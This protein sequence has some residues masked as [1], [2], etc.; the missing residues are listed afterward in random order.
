MKNISFD[1][2]YLL[3]LAIPAIILIVVPFF[4]ARNKDNKLI[5]WTLSVFTHA[6]IIG[7]VALA[8]AGMSTVSILTETTVYVV[9][10]ISHSSAQNLDK[11]DEY[12][13]E[14]K[15]NLPEKTKL[16]VVCF[17]KG[18]AI[19]ASPGRKIKSVSTIDID[20]SSTDIAKALNF[21]ANLFDGTTL[22]RI[23]LITDG[24]D[25]VN[26]SSSTIASTVQRLTEDGIKI[27]AIFLD[28]SVKEGDTEIQLLEAEYSSSTYLNHTN[29]AKFLIQSSTSAPIMLE[30]F[31]RPLG[32][33]E[34][35]FE[36]INQT[37]ISAEAGLST[38]TM[39]LPSDTASTYEYKVQISTE[40]DLSSYNNT[41]TFTQTV[42]GKEK[43]LLIS[44][45]RFDYQLISSIYGERAEID[46][47]VVSA[48]N[49]RVPIVL[50]ELVKY[51]EIVLSDLD[52]REIRNVNAFLDSLDMVVSQ[53]G[54]SLITFG[55]LRTQTNADDPIF[56]KLEEL[57]P[58]NYGNTS[59]DG[60]LYTIVLDVSHSMFM[61][62]KFDI[63]KESAIQLIS[64]LDETDYVCLVTFSGDIKVQTPRKVAD[65]KKELIDYIN[66][67]KTGHGTDIGLG[68]EEAL[69]VIQNL[70]LSENQIMLISDG[71]SF[72]SKVDAVE[73]ATQLFE[74]GTTVSAI[75]TYIPYEGTAGRQTLS[76]IVNTGEGGNFYPI[77]TPSQVSEVVF[78]TVA[79]DI[80]EVIIEREG[81]VNIARFNDEIVNGFAKLPNV[82]G[83]VLS[84]AKHDAK[85]PLTI[86]YQRQNG[87]T[88]TVP[89]YAY[90]THGNGKVA[91]FT[92]NLTSGWTTRWS[93]EDKS[94]LVTNIFN[95]ST[96][97][98][99]VD[100]PFTVNKEY[101]EYNGYIE[102]VPSILDPNATTTIKITYPNG[103][104]ITRTLVFD[105]KK[106]YYNFATE[107]VGTYTIDITYKYDTV[108]YTTQETFEIPYLTEYNAFAS[109]DKFNVYAFMR[110]YGDVLVDE[111]PSLE[112]D[113][114]EVTTYKLSYAIPLL[115]SAV[116]LFVI[117][118]FIRKLRVKKKGVSKKK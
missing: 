53:Y 62:S 74:S 107:K 106:Y 98:K 60:R 22:K 66:G 44:G 23:I 96:P 58:L 102:I 43:I 45:N 88:E 76:E 81:A 17:A 39:A 82:S 72:E 1:N 24:N 11:I 28:N 77:S 2:P 51:D 36:K 100:Y 115:I 87:Y 99:R 105:S 114:N 73:I 78:G 109:F 83:Y 85:V 33:T 49:N 90:R 5:T 26:N 95:A 16:G 69:K 75:N 40:G 67:L 38:I 65:C 29:E 34:A 55:N 48:Q 86:T 41:R 6:I 31:S 92:S 101:D 91:S 42:V 70:K 64:I 104:R 13:A 108:K 71:F 89:L 116:S 112:H 103:R 54:K 27:D 3:L 25:T 14:I 93:E 15:D 47:Y 113:K 61:A 56:K 68:L 110:G 118:V 46:S 35:E 12:I 59:R 30:L 37:V 50:E 57:L 94:T 10:D 79:D 32:D 21:T 52:V 4:I 117:D 8:I 111:I 20:K 9:A 63:A 97:D 80:G 18:N 84:L 7:L 19:L